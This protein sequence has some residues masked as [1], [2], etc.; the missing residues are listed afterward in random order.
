MKT[1]IAIIFSILL[2]NSHL[3]AE[4]K[5]NIQVR[6]LITE[7]QYKSF[8]E[9]ETGTIEGECSSL[10]IDFLNSTFGFFK[11]TAEPNQQVLYIELTDNERNLSSHQTLKEVGF[12]MYIKQQGNLVNTEP[13]YWIFRPVERYIES[14]PDLKEEFIDEVFQTFKIGVAGNKEQLVKNIFSKVEVADDFYFLADKKWFILPLTEKGN[15]IANFSLF[16][17][18]T[19]VQDELIGS[20]ESEVITKVVGNIQKDVAVATNNL[21]VTYPKGSLVVEKDKNDGEEI[22]SGL[23]NGSSIGKKIFI[24]KYLPLVNSDIDIVTPASLT[25]TSNQ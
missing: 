14:L 3:F 17:I 16:L 5:K 4:E 15:N 22:P 10:M 19:S 23:S 11:F 24:L 7:S 25:S 13:V 8:Y 12:K 18:I 9:P 6:F 20:R 1:C 21:A 2:L